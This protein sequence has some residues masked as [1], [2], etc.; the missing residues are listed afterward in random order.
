M[1]NFVWQYCS[2][3]L[4]H[5]WDVFLEFK[6]KLSRVND[7]HIRQK[8]MSTPSYKLYTHSMYSYNFAGTIT[9]LIWHYTYLCIITFLHKQKTVRYSY[10][11]CVCIIK[12]FSQ[13]LTQ[14]HANNN[15]LLSISFTIISL[16]KTCT[17]MEHSL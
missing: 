14:I 12:T 10:G 1:T 2:S 13:G 3:Q 15:W 16:N 6:C 4:T 8:F 5:L 9:K 7:L 17:L 11:K